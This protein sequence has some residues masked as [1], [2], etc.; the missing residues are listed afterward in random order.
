MSSYFESEIVCACVIIRGRK[1]EQAPPDAA[2][3]AATRLVGD[4]AISSPD[5]AEIWGAAYVVGQP[6]D[7]ANL[8]EHHRTA[9][10]RAQISMVQAA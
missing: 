4:G 6:R 2:L 7:L 3:E 1:G 5:L 8:R 10:R 9:A